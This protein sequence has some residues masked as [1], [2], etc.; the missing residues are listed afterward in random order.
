[1]STDITKLHQEL[2]YK[3]VKIGRV[4]CEDFP[5]LYFPEPPY[6]QMTWDIRTAKEI[7]EQCPLRTECLEFAIKADITDG[8]WGGLLPEERKKL[9]K[10]RRLSVFR[11]VQ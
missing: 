11:S 2:I 10:R 7:C 6:G 5:E 8:I 3:I 9:T 4:D 1:M